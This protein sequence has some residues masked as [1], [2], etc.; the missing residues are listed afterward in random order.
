M[1]AKRTGR[2]ARLAAVSPN[3]PPPPHRKEGFSRGASRVGVRGQPRA[4]TAGRGPGGLDPCAPPRQRPLAP[5]APRTPAGWD[6]SPTP[7]FST[8]APSTARPAP[9]ALTPDPLAASL[10]SAGVRT[11]RPPRLR[12]RLSLRL[13]YSRQPYP[14]NRPPRPAGGP[15]PRPRPPPPTRERW[16]WSRPRARPSQSSPYLRAGEQRGVK[17]AGDW[18]GLLKAP[19]PP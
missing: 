15:A 3:R 9:N 7:A 8:G 6:R 10:Y 11:M 2:R 14:G 17:W 12:L 1:Q 16:G 5:E 4:V 13:P 18:S 19:P